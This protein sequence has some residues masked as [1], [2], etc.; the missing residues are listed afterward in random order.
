MAFPND[1]P[2]RQRSQYSRHGRK[3]DDELAH[4]VV[5]ASFL[6]RPFHLDSRNGRSPRRRLEGKRAAATSRP[7]AVRAD[8]TGRMTEKTPAAARPEFL[9]FENGTCRRI[10][11]LV[12]FTAGRGIA[13]RTGGALSRA[14]TGPY[15]AFRAGLRVDAGLCSRRARLRIELLVAAPRRPALHIV[16][17]ALRTAADLGVG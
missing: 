16:G 5:Q 1:I 13:N 11:V 17:P 4:P 6:R 14:A 15:S 3:S 9:V 12:A 2:G 7:S 8:Q 10:G